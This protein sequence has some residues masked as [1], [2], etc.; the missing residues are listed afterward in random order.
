MEIASCVP[1][2]IHDDDKKLTMRIKSFENIKVKHVHKIIAKEYTVSI[3]RT[4]DLVAYTCKSFKFRGY[5][6]RHALV[7]L[8]F[9][10][11][12]RIP[13]RYIMKRWTIEMRYRHA[14]DEYIIQNGLVDSA[15]C[16]YD[17]LIHHLMKVAEVGSMSEAMHDI[18]VQEIP[19]LLKKLIDSSQSQASSENAIPSG[20]ASDASDASPAGDASDASDASPAAYASDAID[21][22]PTAMAVG[23]QFH[24]GGLSEPKPVAQEREKIVGETVAAAVLLNHWEVLLESAGHGC[25]IPSKATCS[26]P[27]RGCGVEKK[28][29]KKFWRKGQLASTWVDAHE[30]SA[31]ISM[32]AKT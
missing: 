6:C 4:E 27:R 23:V 31:S 20:D 24:S 15:A 18:V 7:A 26:F 28:K 13:E 10:G 14:N 16:L 2:I 5:L 25:S 1:T 3:D 19:N 30:L 9:A 17:N 12:A 8:Q 22:A 21:V 11:I 32:D 29:K